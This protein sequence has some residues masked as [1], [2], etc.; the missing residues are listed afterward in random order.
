[1]IKRIN[2]TGRRRILREH[3]QIAFRDENG[4]PAFDAMIELGSYGLP[5]SARVFVE[6]YRGAVSWMR[7]DFGTKAKITGPKDRRLHDFDSAVGIRFRVKVTSAQESHKILAEADGIPLALP[8]DSE[9]KH[10]PLLKP[11]PAPLGDLVFKVSFDGPEPTFQINDRIVDPNEAALAPGFVAVV[12]PAVF[13][14]ILVQAVI[15]E[16]HSDTEDRDD[17]RSRWLCFATLFPGVDEPPEEDDPDDMKRGWIDNA[18]DA[19]ARKIK[20]CEEFEA[21]RSKDKGMT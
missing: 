20:A 7:F 6:A 1:M 9:Q 17:W 3:V 14:E 19:F 12:Y 4:T 18:V 5:D 8:S 13:R 15:I 10:V 2:H 11:E 16:G 21:T